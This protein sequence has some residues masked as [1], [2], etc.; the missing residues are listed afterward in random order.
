MFASIRRIIDESFAISGIQPLMR[1]IVEFTNP[2]AGRYALRTEAGTYSVFQLLAGD[3]VPGI[4]ATVTVELEALTTQ[5]YRIRGVGAVSL[6]A[7][8]TRLTRSAA[9][10]WL[11]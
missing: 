5:A 6:F 10:A 3:V 4:S 11:G 8:K 2:Q 9:A 1:G 7:E